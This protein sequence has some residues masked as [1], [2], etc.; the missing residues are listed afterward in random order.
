MSLP[1]RAESVDSRGRGCAAA[2]PGLPAPY[3]GARL[4]AWRARVSAARR[5]LHCCRRSGVLLPARG[6]AGGWEVVSL[7]ARGQSSPDPAQ[8]PDSEPRC[9][10]FGNEGSSGRGSCASP[11]SRNS[12]GGGL[13]LLA[14]LSRCP[15]RLQAIV[16]PAH[17]RLPRRRVLRGRWMPPSSV[18][19]GFSGN[20]C[21][22]PLQIARTFQGANRF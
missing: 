10:V 15:L 12:G 5:G 13:L 18:P 17:P 3:R 14:R 4:G 2:P 11:G 7:P 19:E 21:R 16:R 8:P 1:R 6:D 22:K 20:C 9:L